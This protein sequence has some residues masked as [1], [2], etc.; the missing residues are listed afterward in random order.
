MTA[1]ATAKPSK[2]GAGRFF[3]DFTV[4]ETIHHAT[5]RTMTEG[6]ASL[7]L[8]LTGARFAQACSDPF[9]KL[10]RLPRSPLDDLLVFNTVFGKTVPDISLNA[11]AN[12]GYADCRFLGPVYPGETLEASS[13]VLGLRENSTK[14]TGVVW[15]RTQGRLN[16]GRPVLE[17][18]RW[19]MVN[20][21]D[22]ASPA[23]APVVPDLPAH[24]AAERLEP[25]T[26]L[27]VRVDLTQSGSPF[28][29]EDYE[30]GERIDHVDG[31]SVTEAEHRLATRLYQNTSRVHFNDHVERHGR[32]GRTIVYGG[33]VI[34]IARAL[35]F[36]GLGNVLHLLAINAGRHVNP[37]V[38]GDTI[39]AWSE[40]LGKA[41][42]PG[43]E[44]I[45]ALR[46]RLVATKDRP[47]ADFPDK[48]AHGAYEEAV[49]LDLDY[50]G[51]V[52]TAKGVR[53]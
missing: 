14:R 10:N 50:W 34:S 36:N 24:V 52:P 19:V 5:P 33:V 43:R 27:R 17:F 3:E 49:L 18:V 45:G 6:D 51:L 42:L 30:V 23:P 31:M 53:R 38:A 2:T 16:T 4:G 47:C 25:P 37:C 22:P 11:V 7:Y 32:Y 44:D 8:A 48:D 15:V 28:L 40:V 41:S 12:L 13:T 35:S 1:A 9:A 21:R 26:G 46:L 20:K 29:F 39:Y